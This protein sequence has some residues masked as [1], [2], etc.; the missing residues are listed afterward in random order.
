M[1]TAGGGSR[2]RLSVATALQLMEFSHQLGAPGEAVT[3]H[4][5]FA[6]KACPQQGD[7]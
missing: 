2:N 4:Q 3:N 1:Q 5:A 7:R 6:D